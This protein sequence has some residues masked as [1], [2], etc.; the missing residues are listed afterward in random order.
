MRALYTIEEADPFNG[1]EISSLFVRSNPEFQQKLLACMQ[2]FHT[3]H[4]QGTPYHGYETSWH[5]LGEQDADDFWVH[6]FLS[7]LESI[8]GG[9]K[10]IGEIIGDMQLVMDDAVTELQKKQLSNLSNNGLLYYLKVLDIHLDDLQ[11]PILDVGTGEEARFARELLKKRPD[12][13]VTSTSVHLFSPNSLISRRLKG[14]NGVGKLVAADGVS[15]PFPDE[16]F[17][18]VVSVNADPYYTPGYQF[19]ESMREKQRLLRTGGVALLCPALYGYNGTEVSAAMIEPLQ[20]EMD[21]ELRP[22]S[23]AA[24]GQ[25]FGH[26]PG[27]I[28]IRK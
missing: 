2:A 4:Q 23:A 16:S 10:E 21:I 6:G 26:V 25:Y 8:S 20:N 22:L 7:A 14:Q 15:M 18:T 12:A 19:A 28:V 9:A 11:D 5:I 13:D 17:Q 27:L 24:A 1:A 3:A